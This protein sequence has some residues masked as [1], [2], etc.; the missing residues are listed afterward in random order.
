MKKLSLA[1]AALFV[2]AAP[3]GD[4][5]GKIAWTHVKNAKEYDALIEQSN[6]AGKPTLLYFTMDG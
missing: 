6:K 4:H 1:I 2:A 3:A 5:G